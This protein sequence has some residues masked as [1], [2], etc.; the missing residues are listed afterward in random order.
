MINHSNNCYIDNNILCLHEVQIW[1]ELV[2]AVAWNEK[3]GV[4]G[5]EYDPEFKKL[6][7]DLAPLKMPISSSKEI[8]IFPEL[9]KDKNAEFDTFIGL[10]GLL[11]DVLPDK[12]GNQLIN[13]WL[14][15]QGRPGDSLN[16][17]EMLCFTGTRGMG[18]LEFEPTTFRENK[19]SFS[20]EIEN[21]VDIAQ[22]ILSKREVYITTLRK[23]EEKAASII[24]EIND[25]VSQWEKFADNVNVLPEIRDEIA[26]TLIN[27]R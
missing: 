17:V 5:F 16:P 20:L 26:K 2:G 25:T 22:K 9:R 18:A 6:N 24:D 23:D 15:H 10:P 12:Y 13:M 4:A 7:W 8:L 11:A 3:T 27:C 14:A 19:Q 1:G 21:L